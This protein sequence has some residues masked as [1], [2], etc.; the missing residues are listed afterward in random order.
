VPPAV[1]GRGPRVPESKK[2]PL[3][4]I[5][6]YTVLVVVIRSSGKKMARES[7]VEF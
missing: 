4:C 6:K 3:A 5:K 1:R 2:M 7:A